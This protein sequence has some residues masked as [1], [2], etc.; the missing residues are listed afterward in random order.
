MK[1]ILLR[2]ELLCLPLL[3][4]I[5]ALLI[6]PLALLVWESI[7]SGGNEVGFTLRRYLDV[8]TIPRYRA[9]F[10]WSVGLS[11]AVAAFSTVACLAPAWLFVRKEFAGKRWLRGAFAL[12]M[13]FSGVIVGFL[14]IIMLGRS[15]FIPEL[16]QR[17][18]GVG[19][20]SGLAYQ[21]SG[22]LLAYLYFEIPRA[23]LT[24]ESALRKFDVRLEA[25]AKSLGAN[26]WQRLVC[27]ILPTIW[28]ALIST[29]AVT[30]TV[31]LGS[32]GAALILSTRQVNLLPLEIFTQYL[33]VPSD[34]AAAAAMAVM[35]TGIA[36]GVN[37]GFR[38]W[39]EREIPH[40]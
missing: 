2:P 10:F 6:W 36:L 1:R 27:V 12:P 37:Y 30:F 32:F 7:V 5:A 11:L 21:I 34:R 40:R 20:F 9:A 31:S 8:V 25:A 39:V 26:R 35:L 22:L 16:T 13:S 28:P 29:F 24:L 18:T 19:L 33:S 23:T 3:A 15:G 38:S 14:M 4:A 17:L